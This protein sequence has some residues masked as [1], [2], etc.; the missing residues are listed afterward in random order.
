MIT[1]T[2]LKIWENFM[3]RHTPRTGSCTP[4]AHRTTVQYFLTVTKNDAIVMCTYMV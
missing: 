1:T 4:F 2:A 3:A